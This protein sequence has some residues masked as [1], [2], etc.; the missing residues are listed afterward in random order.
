MS[1][2]AD[3]YDSD[4][5][6]ESKIK[7]GDGE[8][9][10]TP[11]EDTSLNNSD[12]CSKYQDAAKIANQVTAAVAALAVVDAKVFDICRAGDA[13][14]LAETSQLYKGKNKSGQVIEKGIAFP[15]CVSVNEVVAHMSPLASEAEVSCHQSF[16][17][18]P[19]PLEFII[20]LLSELPLLSGAG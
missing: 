19:L 16:L 8:V 5:Q 15:V 12:V 10:A 9:E 7:G 4:E 1:A 18:P 17:L 20:Y 11:E 6:L 13:M 14:I 3:G 2:L